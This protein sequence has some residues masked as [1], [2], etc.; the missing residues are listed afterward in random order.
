[1]RAVAEATEHARALVS[2]LSAMSGKVPRALL[3]GALSPVLAPLTR[4]LGDDE[5]EDEQ[6]SE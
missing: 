5:P 3:V 1:V 2:T 4:M 6:R